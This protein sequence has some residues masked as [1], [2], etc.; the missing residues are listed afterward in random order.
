MP[1]TDFS[2]FGD[3]FHVIERR[4][5]DLSCPN[6][7]THVRLA[8]IKPVVL[9][10]LVQS[11]QRNRLMMTHLRQFVAR[12]GSTQRV[13]DLTDAEVIRQIT[14]YL[15]I[16]RLRVVQCGGI[17][18]RSAGGGGGGSSA[19]AGAA[20]AV[21]ATPPPPARASNSVG[22]GSRSNRKDKD[23][24]APPPPKPAKTWVEVELLD[25]EG[26]P[27]ANERYEIRLPDGSLQEGRLDGNGRAR[28]TGIDPGTCQV[29]FPDFDAREWREH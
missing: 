24:A 5:D 23:N 10:R 26:K 2:F 15:E 3:R 17:A 12:H 4:D 28:F 6:E 18:E 22:A 1:Y 8:S 20:G 9:S 27:A 29:T 14:H 25:W 7:S 11:A 19:G 13:Y 21:G 16:G